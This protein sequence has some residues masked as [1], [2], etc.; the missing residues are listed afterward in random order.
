MKLFATAFKFSI[1]QVKFLVGN[2]VLLPITLHACY[3]QLVLVLLFAALK[4]TVQIVLILA[5]WFI[6]DESAAADDEKHKE[7]FSN[8]NASM[9][10][11]DGFINDEREKEAVCLESLVSD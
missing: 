2:E 4:L 7:F 3:A 11:D 8:N 1:Y 9:D 5:K 6:L 10:R